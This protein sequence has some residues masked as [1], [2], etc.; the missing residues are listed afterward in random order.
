[1]VSEDFVP[2]NWGMAENL[3]GERVRVPLPNVAP[4]RDPRGD[5]HSHYAGCHSCG[6][7]GLLY[8]INAKV[9]CDMCEFGKV[10]RALQESRALLARW[11]KAPYDGTRITPPLG[12]IAA[13][14][15]SLDR[16][17]P[18]DE[19]E[20]YFARLDGRLPPKGVSSCR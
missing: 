19:Y 12:L 10:R 11:D 1:M 3:M 4:E 8:S 16:T 2:G 18:H 13:T 7:D 15:Q 9:P 6:G 17:L 14:A 5:R 20:A